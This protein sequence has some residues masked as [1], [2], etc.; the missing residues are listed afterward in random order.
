[1]KSKAAPKYDTVRVHD[2]RHHRGCGYEVHVSLD[3]GPVDDSPYHLMS[4]WFRV[5]RKTALADLDAVIAKLTGLRDD[6]R[7]QIE[8]HRKKGK[9]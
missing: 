5:R 7:D 2:L 1:M 6:A 9:A 3:L 8:A 4:L